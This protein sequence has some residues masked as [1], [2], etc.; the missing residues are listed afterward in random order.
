MKRPLS[1]DPDIND[2]IDHIIN[3]NDE[4]KIEQFNRKSKRSLENEY[5]ELISDILSACNETYEKHKE[6]EDELASFTFLVKSYIK[7][8][9]DDYKIHF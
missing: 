8:F 1:D 3:E 7:T 5:K 2:Y 9:S 4:L 6:D